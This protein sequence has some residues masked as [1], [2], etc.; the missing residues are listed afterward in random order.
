MSQFEQSANIK[1]T[2]RRLPGQKL[3][4]WTGFY[5]QFLRA[6]FA[7]VARCS[8]KEAARQVAGTV[9]S[10]RICVY[11]R[12]HVNDLPSLEPCSRD[13]TAVRITHPYREGSK[14]LIICLVYLPCDSDEPP[15]NKEM[16]LMEFLVSSNLNILNHGNE[17]TFVVCNRKEVIDLT[18]GTNNIGNLVSNWHVSDEPSVSDHI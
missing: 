14:E 15:P 11:I 13:A 8:S 16:R 6:S 5:W 1:F 7:E 18:L 10:S 17:P 2:Q 3:T 12:N 4:A 9:L